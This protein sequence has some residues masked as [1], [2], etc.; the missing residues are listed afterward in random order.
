VEAGDL[1]E[2]TLVYMGEA[3]RS[4][5]SPTGGLARWGAGRSGPSPRH[6]S[7][8]EVEVALG[9][10]A[11]RGGYG[12]THGLTLVL[13]DTGEGVGVDD[14]GDWLHLGTTVAARIGKTS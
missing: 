3:G 12:D 9:G 11:S 14:H 1:P 13:A 7:S 4:R 5:S 2:P 6:A 8:T 10:I